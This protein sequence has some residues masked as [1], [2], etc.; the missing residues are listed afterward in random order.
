MADYLHVLQHAA[1]GAT[2]SV[3]KRENDWLFTFANALI[4]YVECPWRVVTEK[5]IAVTDEDD[6]QLFGLKEPVSAANRANALLLGT[7]LTNLQ[8]DL[9]TAD[10][11]LTF[12]GGVQLQVFNNSCAYT[13]WRASF[14]YGEQALTAVGLG[15]GGL[16]FT[17]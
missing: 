11:R 6:G 4:L 13:G 10:L 1:T 3:V 16:D 5:G 2:C 14:R 9:R 15:G 12:E 17:E 7:G 8:V